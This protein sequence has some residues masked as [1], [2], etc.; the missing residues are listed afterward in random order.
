MS[1][2]GE[3]HSQG[4]VSIVGNVHLVRS[5]QAFVEDAPNGICVVQNHSSLIADLEF[6]C[7][8]AQA[9]IFSLRNEKG[10]KLVI[11]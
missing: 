7:P 1:R 9:G 3:G 2:S 11:P 4:V 10:T 5:Q 8:E 6:P